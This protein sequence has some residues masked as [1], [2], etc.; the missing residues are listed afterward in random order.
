MGAIQFLQGTCRF[1]TSY[2]SKIDIIINAKVTTTAQQ[3][4]EN[5]KRRLFRLK[6]N[7]KKTKKEKVEQQQQHWVPS[8]D[9]SL[10]E[11]L[12]DVL[13]KF[14]A[15]DEYRRRQICLRNH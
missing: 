11:N 1:E 2:L 6:F 3:T 4:P 7:I 8:Q 15:S 10:A 12:S 5:T 14:E 13:N 9:K